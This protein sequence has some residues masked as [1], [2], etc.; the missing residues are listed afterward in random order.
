M[1]W[2]IVLHERKKNGSCRVQGP[3]SSKKEANDFLTKQMFAGKNT[4]DYPSAE[5]CELE[6]T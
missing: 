2:V 1:T 3:F 4:E 5:I 6:G